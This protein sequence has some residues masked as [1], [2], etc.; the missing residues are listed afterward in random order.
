M[1]IEQWVEDRYD[2][3]N[4]GASIKNVTVYDKHVYVRLDKAIEV[5]NQHNLSTMAQVLATRSSYQ[6]IKNG[7]TLIDLNFVLRAIAMPACIARE[8]LRKL[9]VWCAVYN[10]VA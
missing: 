6:I 5:C 7:R 4:N 1:K 9:I 2:W 10:E 3:L 8:L